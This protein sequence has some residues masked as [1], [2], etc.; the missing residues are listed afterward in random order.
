[1]HFTRIVAS[2]SYENPQCF[3]P[4]LFQ[5][6]STDPL[7]GQVNKPALLMI[8]NNEEEWEVEDIFDARSF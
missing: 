3:L 4:N 5:K 8:I 2:S 7:T 1:M 6:A